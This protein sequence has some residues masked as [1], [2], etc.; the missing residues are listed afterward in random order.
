MGC[1]FGID[2]CVDEVEPGEKAVLLDVNVIVGVLDMGVQSQ[3]PCLVVGQKCVDVAVIGGGKHVISRIGRV[4]IIPLPSNSGSRYHYNF[5]NSV[6]NSVDLF[7]KGL[8]ADSLYFCKTLDLSH[9]VNVALKRSLPHKPD[10][11]FHYCGRMHEQLMRIDADFPAIPVVC[12][13]FFSRQVPGSYTSFGIF[14]RRSPNRAG[15][16]FARRGVDKSGAVANEVLTDFV[17]E[18][19][20]GTGAPGTPAGLPHGAHTQ[21]VVF[22]QLRGSIPLYWSQKPNLKYTP[23]VIIDSAHSAQESVSTAAHFMRLRQALW[24][25]DGVLCVN[26]IDKKGAQGRLG[27]RMEEVIC[28]HNANYP[29]SSVEH[30]WWDF[31][32]ECKGMRFENVQDLVNDTSDFLRVPCHNDMK[33]N[34]NDGHDGSSPSHT[35]WN[36]YSRGFFCGAN[37][38]Y[39]ACQDQTRIVRTNCMDCLDRTNVVQS[40]YAR[41]LVESVCATWLSADAIGTKVL[42]GSADS[43]FRNMWADHADSCSIQYSGTPALKTDYTRTGQRTQKGILADGINSLTRYYLNAYC[44]GERQDGI[45][46]FCGN[47]QLEHPYSVSH[48]KPL[49]TLA[50]F[51]ALVIA[52]IMKP[53]IT[54]AEPLAYAGHF[55]SIVVTALSVLAVTVFSAVALL[56]EEGHGS[57]LEDVKVEDD[58]RAHVSRV[59]AKSHLARSNDDI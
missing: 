43:I 21:L 9:P 57:L 8:S 31:H 33:T 58:G 25:K 5:S 3:L 27:E 40:A 36:S 54:P 38:N 37:C 15:C 41:W 47:V 26:L 49:V 50:V 14:S 10:P 22:S 52:V 45:D 2:E 39:H 11:H 42:T 4:G 32:A 19:S 24:G 44:D 34:N 12:G 13:F 28:A 35:G 17:V 23:P 59:A 7:Q 6:I 16:R 1:C 56:A 18:Q 29:D 51:A 20:F 30:V 48:R 55:A 46:F 53:Y